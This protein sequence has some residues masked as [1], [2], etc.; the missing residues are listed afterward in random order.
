MA[1]SVAED[2][3]SEGRI[4]KMTAG[5]FDVLFSIEAF[6]SMTTALETVEDFEMVLFEFPDAVE[7]TE[8]AFS[9]GAML[10]SA[11]AADS[12]DV[13]TG[14]SEMFPQESPL[15]LPQD[16]RHRNNHRSRQTPK[17]RILS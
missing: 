1:A 17:H 14:S 8:E 10:T 15:P 12:A 2:P 6:D 9:A 11:D 13:A 5:S 16:L 7:E 3:A 4:A